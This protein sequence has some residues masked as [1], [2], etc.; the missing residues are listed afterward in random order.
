MKR[1]NFWTVVR[2]EYIRVIGKVKYWILT[3]TI[4]IGFGLLIALSALG[5]ST[6]ADLQSKQAEGK[7]DFAYSDA[8]G[9][10]SA[11]IAKQMGGHTTSDAIASRLKPS[12]PSL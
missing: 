4:P 9:H 8:S 3:L 11:E 7:F 5:G 12:V 6:A 10:I 1:H 2:F